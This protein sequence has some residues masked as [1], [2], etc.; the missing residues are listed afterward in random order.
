MASNFFAKVFI[1]IL[2][3]WKMG[4]MSDR[5]WRRTIE[6]I[7]LAKEV[8]EEGQLPDIRNMAYRLHTDTEL[9]EAELNDLA[10]VGIVQLLPEGWHVVNFIK[11]QG[12]MSD[13]ERQSRRR[14]R[15]KKEEY[16]EK[17]TLMSQDSHDAVTKRDTEK[18]RIEKK[19]KEKILTPL[20]AHLATP[21]MLNEWG[22][23]LQYH[24]DRGTPITKG[25]ALLQYQDFNDWGPE[26]SV[27]V[28]QHSRKNNYTGLVDP[29]KN[30]RSEKKSTAQRNF[31]AG[32]AVKDGLKQR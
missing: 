1:E 8:N 19:R 11:W 25:T 16:Y 5:L 3:D 21:E 27:V 26:K 22:E 31:E 18:K 30:Q 23:W 10:K 12:P 2:D 20:P 28:L 29:N 13:A 32:M 9:L 17:I 6:M 24:E 14:E 15:L 7:L 4:S